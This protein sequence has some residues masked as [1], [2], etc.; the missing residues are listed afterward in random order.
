MPGRDLQ[1][2]AEI[3]VD[4]TGQNPTM[5]DQPIAWMHSL[6][7]ATKPLGVIF[8]AWGTAIVSWINGWPWIAIIGGGSSIAAALIMRDAT[9]K[10][11]AAR[12]HE[13]E[14][15]VAI[16]AAKVATGSHV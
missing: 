9:R 12:I 1:S 5:F 6:S 15:E 10:K 4:P 14:T 2:T 3:F 11:D 16:L 7:G 8:P 13:L